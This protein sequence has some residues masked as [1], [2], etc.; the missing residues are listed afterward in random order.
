MDRQHSVA[1][2]G[3][4]IR[5]GERE[6]RLRPL[7]LGDLAEMKACIVSRR[8]SPLE[9]RPTAW[10]EARALRGVTADEFEDYLDSF[11]GVAHVFW[12]M[13]REACP[14]LD[15][16]DA[17]KKCLGDCNEQRFVDLQAR[18]DQATGFL[19]DVAPLGNSSGQARATMTT[20][21]NGLTSIAA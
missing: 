13:A 11:D 4:F 8:T 15:S 5:I 21:R 12:L 3:G 6:Y 2:I 18:L 14:A 16:L 20:A 9:S 10:R 7:T 17:A 19:S 1:G